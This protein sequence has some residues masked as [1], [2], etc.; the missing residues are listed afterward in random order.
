MDAFLKDL[1]KFIADLTKYVSSLAAKIPPEQIP[2]PVVPPYIPPVVPT[3][4]KPLTL[5]EVMMAHPYG[6]AKGSLENRRAMLQLANRVCK[7][8]GL[9]ISMTADV[10]ATIWGESGWNQYCVNTQSKDYG[11][12]Q[13][14]KKYYLIEYKMTPVEALLNPERQLRI[15]ARNFK[16]V[17]QSN[18]VAF[19]PHDANW[20]TNRLRGL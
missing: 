16:A 13:F 9:S 17:R 3:P 4:S 5:E 18:W 6:W 19:K 8:E 20:Q 1:A 11:L 15:M 7:E 2:P 12:C 14:S 10:R